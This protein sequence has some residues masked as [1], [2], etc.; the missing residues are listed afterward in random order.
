MD[1]RDAIRRHYEPRIS[2]HRESHDILDWADRAAQRARFAVL[3]DH[4]ALAGRSL[5]DVGCGLGDLWGYLKE[6]G[7]EA[8]YTGVDLLDSMLDLA[9]RH[10]PHATFVAGDPFT[11]D[12]FPGRR[13]DVVF[14][15]GV[16]NLDLGNN[17]E[18]LAW[19]VPR[20]WALA[21]EHLVFNLLH[22]RAAHHYDH[23]FYYDPHEVLAVLSGMDLSAAVIDDYLPNDF[24]VLCARALTGRVT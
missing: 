23:C 4:V 22:R 12:P 21:G 10:Y 14:G 6:R 7:V 8:E 20:L 9:R 15:S 3:A 17:M 24:T 13:F 16:F 2:P 5:L 1:R 18:F 11:E 19:G